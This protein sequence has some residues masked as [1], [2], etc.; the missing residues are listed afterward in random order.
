VSGSP[1]PGVYKCFLLCKPDAKKVRI[2]LLP[3]HN[4]ISPG[5]ELQAKAQESFSISP[6][7]LGS[8]REVTVTMPWRALQIFA[9]PKTKN[10]TE[11]NETADDYSY[12]IL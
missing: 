3:P 6:L 5:T 8:S 7:P 12:I 9:V 2:A 1:K 4:A 10:G 11:K